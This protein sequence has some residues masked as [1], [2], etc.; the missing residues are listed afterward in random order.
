VTE[1]PQSQSET[2]AERLER[3]AIEP[4]VALSILEQLLTVLETVHAGG[5]VHGRITPEVIRLDPDG[6]ATF[7]ELATEAASG[8]PTKANGTGLPDNP[9]YMAPEQISGDF[10]DARTD[11]FALGVIAFEMLTGKNPFS[12]GEGAPPGTVV[13]RIVYRPYPEI[14]PDAVPDLPAQARSIVA[15]AMARDPG[16]RF[17]DATSFLGVLKPV[18]SSLE[19]AALATGAALAAGAAA[20]KPA[21]GSPKGSAAKG[22]AGA[23][24]KGTAT[25]GAAAA[26]TAAA[27]TPADSS[28]PGPDEGGFLD[29]AAAWLFEMRRNWAPYFLA[30]G[31]VV[32]GLV[33]VVLVII[34]RTQNTGV[35]ETTAVA[36]TVATVTTAQ[37]VLPTDPTTSTTVPATTSTSVTTTT[38]PGKLPASMTLS[39][40]AVTYTGSPAIPAVQ[41]DPDGLV[42]IFTY[43]QGDTQVDAPTN[44]GTYAVTAIIDDA[45]YQGTATGTLEIRKA[46]ARVNVSGWSG[47]YTGTA[48]QAIGSATGVK[49]ETLSSLLNFTG[50]FTNVPG[51]TSNW[52]FT[53]NTNYNPANGSVGIVIRKATAKVSVSGWNR[54]YDGN[55][56]R[57][58]LNYARGVLGEN[59]GNLVTLGAQS[60]ISPPGGPALWNLP[61]TSTTSAPVAA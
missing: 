31:I 8:G 42:V 46:D 47:T 25:K 21:A 7:T 23:A 33:I 30:G 60:Y 17:A 58:V 55:P 44:A 6:R 37:A 18:V 14:A 53:G 41:T 52:S 48:H 15:T 1:A 4:G 51:G 22:K 39:A 45:Q 24:A 40:L 20:T 26:G 12:A 3:G 50:S 54:A 9:G 2:L 13:Y 57:A 34:S 5:A 11:V 10:V 43:R 28:A 27:S 36:S 38:V 19:G 16:T 29:A 35:T 61:G 49:G 59:L 56:H 32:V